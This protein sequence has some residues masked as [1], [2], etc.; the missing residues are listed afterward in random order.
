LLEEIEFSIL[1]SVV[2]RFEATVEF[3]FLGIETGLIG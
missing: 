1:F 3:T 2:L